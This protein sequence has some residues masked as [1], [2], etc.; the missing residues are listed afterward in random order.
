MSNG[1][2]QPDP[3]GRHQFRWWDGVQWTSMVSDGGV[4]H[5]EA[6][7]PPPPVSSPPPPPVPVVQ[8]VVE[9]PKSSSKRPFVFV[10]IGA[11]VVIAVAAVVISRG[12]NDATRDSQTAEGKKYVAAMIAGGDSGQFTPTEAKCVAESSVD[13][14]GV[15][16]LQDAGVTPEM[17]AS[18]GSGGTDLDLM[19]GFEPSEAQATALIDTMFGCVDFGKMFADQMGDFG[20]NIS[21]DELHCVGD[22]LTNN[23][24]FRSYLAQSMVSTDTSSSTADDDMN[25]VMEKA[26]SE[27][28]VNMDELAPS[29]T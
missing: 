22:A 9:A 11:V 6:D 3:H 26:F 2:W 4:T 14:I 20:L 8:V 17:I 28:G 7:V 10:A 12:G 27:C 23:P 18:G 21:S 25:A 29:S 1:S 13:V 24:Q 19:P 5:D 16:A 15:K